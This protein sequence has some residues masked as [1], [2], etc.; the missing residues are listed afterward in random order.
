MLLGGRGATGWSTDLWRMGRLRLGLVLG[1]GN[2]GQRRSTRRGRND[3]TWQLPLRH[4]LRAREP[5]RD[6]V[7]AGMLGRHLGNEIRVRVVRAVAGIDMDVIDVKDAGPMV[8]GGRMNV[9]LPEERG[10]KRQ[11]EHQ[12]DRSGASH[13]A[14]YMDMRD[15][16][17]V[18]RTSVSCDRT[19]E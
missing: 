4:R 15:G 10:A 3:E 14:D 1:P 6:G 5:Q 12:D 7:V 18:E 8:V 17:Q 13:P 11:Q 9:A 19:R 16:R 2:L